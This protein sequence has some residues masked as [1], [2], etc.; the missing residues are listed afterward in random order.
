MSSR[1]ENAIVNDQPKVCSKSRSPVG[2]ARLTRKFSAKPSMP[3][4]PG[5]AQSSGGGDRNGLRVPL[6][7]DRSRVWSYDL[8]DCFSDRQTCMS[9]SG[10]L[11]VVS[12]IF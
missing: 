5:N 6:N 1:D 4:T 2:P 10:Q 11:L 7:D 12:A 8:F 9:A 3:M